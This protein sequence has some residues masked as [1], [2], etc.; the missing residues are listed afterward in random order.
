MNE[1][2]YIEL[3]EPLARNN[4]NNNLSTIQRM[5]KKDLYCIIVYIYA[6]LSIR[7][8]HL[9]KIIIITRGDLLAAASLGKV[10][11]HRVTHRLLHICA[12]A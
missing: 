8:T 2:N 5:L 10:Q 3:Y 9:Q 12:N 4:N 7:L 1:L 6:F 11:V